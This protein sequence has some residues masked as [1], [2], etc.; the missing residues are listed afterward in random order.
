MVSTKSEL[1]IFLIFTENEFHFFHF[2]TLVAM[3]ILVCSYDYFSP[4]F[5]N[6]CVWMDMQIYACMAAAPVYVVCLCACVAY[7]HM[8]EHMCEGYMLTFGIVPRDPSI[9]FPSK[10]VI[11]FYWV[12][13]S[14][15]V[16]VSHVGVGA[17]A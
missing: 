17:G 4:Y 15:H 5:E 13:M 12:C 14:E 6:V 11:L 8:H 7:G 3:N 2:I 16:Y 1:T 10:V 9:L